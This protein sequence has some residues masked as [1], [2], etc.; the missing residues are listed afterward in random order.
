[1]QPEA[2][3][4]KPRKRHQGQNK[5]QGRRERKLKL[6]R[7]LTPEEYEEWQKR[8]NEAYARILKQEGEPEDWGDDAEF[9]ERASKAAWKSWWGDHDKSSFYIEDVDDQWDRRARLSGRT[10]FE[11][12]SKTRE[13]MVWESFLS[14]LARE[15]GKTTVA[16]AREAPKPA[17]TKKEPK[18]PAPA[19]KKSMKGKEKEIDYSVACPRKGCTGFYF[20]PA[21]G[22]KDVCK[23]QHPV[24]TESLVPGSPVLPKSVA[25]SK[26]MVLSK[27]NA[28]DKWFKNANTV[29]CGA[30]TVT[31][32]HAHDPGV[33]VDLENSLGAHA[34][35]KFTQYQDID[36]ATAPK[37]PGAG[38]S[39]KMAEPTIG[40]EI[41]VVGYD[42]DS[43]T[44][45]WHES[46]GYV[47][48]LQDPYKSIKGALC[49]TATT[50]PTLS[51]A[52]VINR[53]GQLVGWHLG[54]NDCSA[55]RNCF[56][57]V[58]PQMIVDFGTTG[59]S[60]TH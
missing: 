28:E 10:R 8:K 27:K 36:L 23:Y 51:G 43:G 6:R 24:K 12:H 1:M 45:S 29:N 50:K 44:A 53:Q 46:V 3:D 57:A 15:E 58:T 26:H 42:C 17:P 21:T 40:E 37:P 11:S 60:V 38:A 39:Y 52:A 31:M 30:R 41:W 25:R 34:L 35:T 18:E 47:E 19:I 48:E 54:G 56:I 9:Q 33:A 55:P 22:K 7:K 20:H 32:H 5:K 59:L 49:H 13:P 2:G 14:T 16:K 4:Y